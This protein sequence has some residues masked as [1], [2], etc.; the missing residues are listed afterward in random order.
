[1]IAE[2]P[3]L[4]DAE[5]VRIRYDELRHAGYTWGAALTLA[6]TPAVD[7][8]LARR[9]RAHGCPVATAVRILLP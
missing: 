3:D 8:E 6:S 1:M 7:L 4:V 9:L 5:D 2:H